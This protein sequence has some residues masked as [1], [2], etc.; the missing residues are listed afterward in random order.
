MR[1]AERWWDEGVMSAKRRDPDHDGMLRHPCIALHL[2]IFVSRM[3]TVNT[4]LTRRDIPYASV[5]F[6]IPELIIVI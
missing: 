4:V 1:K 6:Q 5:A 3:Y 2:T